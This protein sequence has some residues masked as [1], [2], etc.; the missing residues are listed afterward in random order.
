[1]CMADTSYSKRMAFAF[2][3]DIKEVFG[4]KYTYEQ[5]VTAIAFSLNNSFYSVMK[6]KMVL[7]LRDLII[8]NLNLGL[9]QQQPR[10]W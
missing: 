6:E 3:E 1:M 10:G 5:K 9:L 8:K 7:S 4:G 2:L